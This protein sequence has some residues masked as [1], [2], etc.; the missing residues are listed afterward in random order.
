M[1][2]LQLKE[3][4]EETKSNLVHLSCVWQYTPE[5][6]RKISGF[7]PV[8]LGALSKVVQ[9]VNLYTEDAGKENRRIMIIC[10]NNGA[11]H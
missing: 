11:I 2:N 6:Q 7:T 10:F 3:F 1:R 4:S 8:F 9:H 5:L